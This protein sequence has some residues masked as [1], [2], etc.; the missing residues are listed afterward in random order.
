MRA[1]FPPMKVVLSVIR[2]ALFGLVIRE[3]A[4]LTCSTS[5]DTK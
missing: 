5:Y 1:N 2:A 4:C 3:K